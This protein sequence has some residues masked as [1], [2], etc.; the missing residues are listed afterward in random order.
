MFLCSKEKA[1]GYGDS[2]SSEEKTI[3]HILRWILF[4][5]DMKKAED[6]SK[7]EI[8]QVNW[9]HVFD[10]FEKHA[11]TP[12]ASDVIARIPE[13][14]AEVKQIW[15]DAICSNVFAYSRLVKQ[16]ERVIS[17]L[18]GD[19]VPAV[20]VKGT[21]AA[22]YYPSPQLR[23][24]GDVDL[25]VKP[26][27]YD[28]AVESLIGI[29]ARESTVELEAEKGRHRSFHYLCISLELHHFFSLS[30]HREQ[31]EALDRLLFDAISE[32]SSILPDDEN[33][34]VLLSHIS[35]HLENGLGLRQIVD[36]MMFVRSRLD[37]NKWYSSFM[38]K[39][40]ITGFKTLAEITTKMCQKHLGLSEENIT[41][42][43]DADEEV[44]DALM[45]YVIEC[46]NFGKSRE[47]FKSQGTSKMPSIKHPIR[48]FKYVQ[49]HGERGWKALKKHPWLRPFAWIR[50]TFRYIK[51]SIQN[52]ISPKKLKDI[53][54]E[55]QK[56]N[57][58]F[59]ALG[60]K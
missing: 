42:C 44:C 31:A 37:D 25:L 14:Y 9:Q 32:E 6:I 4:P 41:W 24:M 30:V 34:L 52:R 19:H 36:W 56:R 54:N 7:T 2:M 35:Q 28:H 53:Y 55:G 20:V 59:E 26:E 22:K 8:E 46:G 11:I 17:A 51:L 43:K 13:E 39:A 45:E 60:I 29:G 48:L 18:R 57:E 16:Q 21:S 33:G 12:I 15:K 3:L 58:M 27:D 50:Q 49:S 10:F 23:S 5:A 47:L 40:E 1:K 38:K